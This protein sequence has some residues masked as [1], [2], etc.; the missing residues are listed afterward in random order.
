M[1]VLS[2]FSRM[3]S[4]KKLFFRQLRRTEYGQKTRI[5]NFLAVFCRFLTS[6]FVEFSLSVRLKSH[7]SFILAVPSPKNGVFH[8][9][10]TSLHAPV[11]RGSPTF[12]C[13][14]L[15]VGLFTGTNTK[16][17]DLC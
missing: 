10:P 1:N 15:D 16:P 4:P 14:H 12:G 17:K 3:K 2:H 8:R 5:F 7:I 6:F 11:C 13:F 9:K